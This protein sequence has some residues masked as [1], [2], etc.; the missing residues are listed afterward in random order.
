[1]DSKRNPLALEGEYLPFNGSTNERSNFF[2]ANDPANNPLAGFSGGGADLSILQGQVDPLGSGMLNAIRQ[3]REHDT[4]YVQRDKS[5]LDRLLN[6]TTERD[7]RID[8]HDLTQTSEVCAFL[9]QKL[10]L[11]CKAIYERCKDDVNNWLAR[12]RIASRGDLISFATNELQALK[13]TLEQRRETYTAYLRRRMQR[14][15]A[16]PDMALLIQAESDDLRAE[17]T[18]HLE[19]LRSLEDH[20]RAAIKERVG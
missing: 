11:E 7:K 9:E 14:L 8:Q 15:Q 13:D 10:G 12:H 20:F 6:R 5:F 1:M 19:F 4:Q 3:V 17:L 18:Q 16:N 2:Q